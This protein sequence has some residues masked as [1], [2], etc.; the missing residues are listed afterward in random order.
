MDELISTPKTIQ[1]PAVP[2]LGCE[3]IQC[4]YMAYLEYLY[5]E[6]GIFIILSEYLPYPK[7][8]YLTISSF[9][10]KPTAPNKQFSSVG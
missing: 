4:I 5:P 9:L 6:S 1:F 10:V 7:Y 2:P 3:K 8:L